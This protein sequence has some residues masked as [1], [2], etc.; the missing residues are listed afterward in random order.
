MGVKFKLMEEGIASEREKV[1]IDS[2]RFIVIILK[3]RQH[4]HQSW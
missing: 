2:N 4:V 3:P 1:G